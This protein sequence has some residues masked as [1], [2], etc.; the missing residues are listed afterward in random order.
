MLHRTLTLLYLGRFRQACQRIIDRLSPHLIISSVLTLKS[1]TSP[2]H[3][4][5]LLRSPHPY[6]CE[7]GRRLGIVPRH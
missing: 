1:V 2:T 3:Q 5:S 7:N 4:V 6:R